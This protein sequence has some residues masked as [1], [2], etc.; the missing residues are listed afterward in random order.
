MLAVVEPVVVPVVEAVVLAVVE[1]VVLA[2]V[3]PVVLPVVE[4]VVL[5]VVEPVVVPVVDP[6]VLPVVDAVVL[7]VVE[8][9]VLPVVEPV[10]LA[11]NVKR[12]NHFLSSVLSQILHSKTVARSARVYRYISCQCICYKRTVSMWQDFYCIAH[13]HLALSRHEFSHQR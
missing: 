1:P 6:V 13:S 7:P 4:P 3:E 5:P 12:E 8:P 9:V 2:V 11:R 10:V